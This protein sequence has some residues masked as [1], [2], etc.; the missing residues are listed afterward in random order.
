VQPCKRART[1]HTDEAGPLSQNPAGGGLADVD[2]MQL[3]NIPDL[4]EKSK[5]NKFFV[6]FGGSSA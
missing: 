1:E 2:E 3:V 6:A 5:K 4:L